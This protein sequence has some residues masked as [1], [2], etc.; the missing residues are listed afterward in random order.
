MKYNTPISLRPSDDDERIIRR[1]K[2]HLK[3][4]RQK[5][6]SANVIRFALNCYELTYPD[7]SDIESAETSDSNKL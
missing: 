2:A 4:R 3:R 7:Y 5:P 6:T 1:I